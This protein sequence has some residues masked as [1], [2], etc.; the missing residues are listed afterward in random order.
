MLP[1]NFLRQLIGLYGNSIQ[2]MV[3]SYLESAMDAF[4]TNHKAIRDSFG[5]TAL[6]DIAK[7]N[8]AMFEE[9]SKAFVP[10]GTARR[11][12]RA[13][14]STIRTRFASRRRSA[15]ARSSSCCTSPPTTS[16]R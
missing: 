5:G 7:R 10:A 1:V 12:S 8:M 11:I 16:A 14:S 15:T 2:G 3:P 6:A 13:S 9:A 4:Q